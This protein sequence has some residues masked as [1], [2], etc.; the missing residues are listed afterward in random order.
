MTNKI[1][2]IHEN[3]SIKIKPREGIDKKTWREINDILRMQD[4]KW[5]GDGKESCW[6]KPRL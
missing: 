2:V 1:D 3:G 5:F 6:I 4:F